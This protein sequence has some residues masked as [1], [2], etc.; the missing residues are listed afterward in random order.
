MASTAA[1]L[2]YHGG[3]KK[4]KKIPWGSPGISF[5]NCE[6]LFAFNLDLVLLPASQMATPP[7][8]EEV[9]T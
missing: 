1:C 8:P 4:E 7:E 2:K 9:I 3:K 5:L 6:Q